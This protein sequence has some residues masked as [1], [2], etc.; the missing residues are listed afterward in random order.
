MKEILQKPIEKK[1]KIYKSGGFVMKITI[2]LNRDELEIALDT[3]ALKSLS[4][5]LKKPN[6][7]KVNQENPANALTPIQASPAQGQPVQPV[8]NIIPVQMQMPTAPV[9]TPT[10]AAV[11]TQAQTY[12][13]DQLAVAATQLMDVGKRNELIALLNSF[14]VQALTALPKEQYGAF[15]TQLRVLGAKI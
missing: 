10:P 4:T 8:Q 3:G 15:A 12:T 6:A 2:E 13:M 9:Q 7:E 11:P 14:G 5:A 1:V